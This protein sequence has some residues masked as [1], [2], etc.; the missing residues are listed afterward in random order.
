MYSLII[1]L[2]DVNAV[3]EKLKGMLPSCDYF[4]LRRDCLI[5]ECYKGSVY[6]KFKNEVV[7]KAK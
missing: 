7:P 6:V 3:F 5:E 4:S 1:L 2:F